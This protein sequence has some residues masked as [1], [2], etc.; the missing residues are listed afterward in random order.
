MLGDP[1]RL[2]LVAEGAPRIFTP[3]YR[4]N[5]SD[6]FQSGTCVLLP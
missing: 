6:S 4:Y 2:P 1:P 3:A 5:L